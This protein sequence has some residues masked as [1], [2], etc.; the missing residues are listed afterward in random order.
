MQAERPSNTFSSNEFNEHS[1]VRI[2]VLFSDELLLKLHF[3][4]ILSRG[5]ILNSGIN[6]P[7]RGSSQS[8]Q[9]VPITQTMVPSFRIVAYYK[10][11]EE[12]VSASMWIDVADQCKQVPR[13]CFL[14]H[15]VL[16]KCSRRD[17]VKSCS[18]FFAFGGD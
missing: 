16:T 11:R 3:L 5:A 6:S 10:V 15:A 12:V 7:G 17:K 4:K 1:T 14:L 2:S 9:R 18:A 8:T 13:F